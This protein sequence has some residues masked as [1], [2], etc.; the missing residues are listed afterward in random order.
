MEKNNKPKKEKIEITLEQ[1]YL[2]YA[3]S[4]ILSRALP[5]IDGF[6]P[7]HRK[8]LYTMYKMNLLRG[9]KTKS[10]NVVG[11]T[12]KLNPHGDQSIYATLVRMSTGNESLL[13]PYVESKGNFGKVFSKD[14]HYAASRYTEVKLTP[15]MKHVFEDI[16][17]NT[18]D[19]ELNYDGSMYEPSLLPVKF[20]NILVN[21]NRG[22][23]VGMASSICSF[24][25]AE[26][27]EATKALLKNPNA[28]IQKYIQG[29]DF[30]TGGIIENN[31]EVFKQI[32]DQ[33]TGSILIR[34]NWSYDKKN[35][36]IEIS[37]IPYTTTIES[38][39]EKT[40][41]L[42]KD[43]DTKAISDIRD[44]SDI[45]GLKIA[46]DLKRGN[47]PK[48]VIHY[49]YAKTTL[50]DSFSCN[51]NLIVNGY[52]K[53]M[54]VKEILLHWIDFRMG[55]V[56]RRLKYDIHNLQKKLHLITGLK[57]VLLDIDRV[58]S[59]IR[60]T[61]KDS[62]VIPR[63]QI[64]FDLDIEQAEFV[65]NIKLR[66]INK[67]YIINRVQEEKDLQDELIRLKKIYSSDEL[68]ANEISRELDEIKKEFALERKS[69]I[70]DFEEVSLVTEEEVS[71]EEVFIV[72]TEEGYLK[73]MSVAQ[74]QKDEDH[75]L[76]DGDK[77]IDTLN[78][79]NDSEL[80][81]FSDNQVVYKLLIHE[82]PFVDS[83]T[84]GQ[85]LPNITPMQNYE[86]IIKAIATKSFEE[87]LLFVYDDA[88]ATKVRIDLY[89][90]K[91]NRSKLLNAY[92]DHAKLLGIY[93]VTGTEYLYFER[94]SRSNKQMAVSVNLIPLSATRSSSGTRVM[95]M[96]KQSSI[97]TH[98]L[99][100]YDSY[101]KDIIV[102]KIPSNGFIK[103]K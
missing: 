58:V 63:L 21:P 9:K 38:I 31:P 67:E 88:K 44:E 62:E 7:A 66:N 24:N 28:K 33:G 97:R 93:Q 20:P 54:G 84:L 56:R 40:V 27:V 11:S 46:I 29:P 34:P 10:A 98:K 77:I 18:V 57:K 75:R 43:G 37:Q 79:S 13:H 59:L 1:N 51:F 2:P 72:L 5:E 25:L 48:E 16:D 83:G 87:E 6:K 32:I 74:Y 30:P 90:T 47:D 76:K 64:H 80:L 4:V 71:E 100:Q 19:F 82:L 42:I 65:A 60:E 35:R 94:K 12:M 101:V 96:T 50:E 81:L 14:M 23:A 36:C 92:S 8:V 99:Y 70:E 91:Q 3:M 103:E 89:Q 61:K 41:K 45:N 55:C 78:T 69:K 85:Y 39:I 95:N 15:I 53:T 22:I 49:L 26:I 102:E 86:K 17:K 73:K 52:P 68:I